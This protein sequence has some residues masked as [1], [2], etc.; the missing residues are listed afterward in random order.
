M[1]DCGCSSVSGPKLKPLEEALELLLDHA[2]AI[3]GVE[4]LPLSASLERVLAAPV[5]SQV[6]VPPWD[7]SAMDGYAIN[8]A[9]MKGAGTR[10]P[11]SQRIPAG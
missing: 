6:T 3:E 9:D 1:S 2:R 7:N 11:V 10:L 5:S 4:T 8:T